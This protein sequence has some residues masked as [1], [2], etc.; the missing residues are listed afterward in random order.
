MQTMRP[1]LPGFAFRVSRFVSGAAAKAS[2]HG[3]AS[4]M[5]AARMKVRRVWAEGGAV[6]M[7]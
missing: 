6:L 7:V 2:S 3:S 4:V 1:G 5:P